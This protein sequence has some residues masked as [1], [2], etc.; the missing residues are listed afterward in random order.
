M[1]QSDLVEKTIEITN[2]TYVYFRE[3]LEI[4]HA[5][6]CL[7]DVTGFT[8]EQL[9]SENSF[10]QIIS[11]LIRCCLLNHKPYID[12]IHDFH[13]SKTYLYQINQKRN[14]KSF[15]AESTYI[16]LKHIERM[17]KTKLRQDLFGKMISFI[18]KDFLLL[19]LRISTVKMR[20]KIFRLILY[21]LR[22]YSYSDENNLD[23]VF[24]FMSLKFHT[25]VNKGIKSLSKIS[26]THLKLNIKV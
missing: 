15:I 19:Q 8:P 9:K 7:S 10:T 22:M 26:Y 23:R 12:T 3:L 4:Y 25:S 6:L 1:F 18:G 14:D 20:I 16:F 21:Y 24:H 2:K 13:V 17:N 5:I 11:S